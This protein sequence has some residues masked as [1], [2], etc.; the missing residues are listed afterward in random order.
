MP[1][2]QFCTKGTQH[3]CKEPNIR[4]PGLQH[5][6]CK[7]PNIRNPGLQHEQCKEPNIGFQKEPRITTLMLDSKRNPGLQLHQ[8]F[9]DAREFAPPEQHIC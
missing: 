5:E 9:C 8:I 3:R 4:N 7:E 1:V 2:L 6:Q